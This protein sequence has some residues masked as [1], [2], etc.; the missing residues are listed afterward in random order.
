M[1]LIDGGAGGSI[2]MLVANPITALTNSLSYSG[3]GAGTLQIIHSGSTIETYD[4]FFRVH[5]LKAQKS[6]SDATKTTIVSFISGAHGRGY[7][8]DARLTCHH[9]TTTECADWRLSGMYKNVSGT[10][11]GIGFY[12]A[13]SS[14]NVAALSGT[15]DV[16][17]NNIVVQGTGTSTGS[18]HWGVIMSVSEVGV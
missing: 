6:T 3:A 9:N 5:G 8:V 10:M 11:T 13:L 17:G 12:T 1:Q 2:T 4:A 16:S 15:L 7:S 14:S 18:F